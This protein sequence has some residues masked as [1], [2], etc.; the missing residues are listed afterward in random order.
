MKIENIELSELIKIIEVSRSKS[1]V[2]RKLGICDGTHKNGTQAKKLNAIIE[3]N[4]LDT[5]HFVTNFTNTEIYNKIPIVIH[6]CNSIK[7]VGIKIGIAKEHKNMRSGYYTRIKKYIK[8]NNINIDHFNCLGRYRN[9]HRRFDNDAVFTM[10]TET[11]N[12][13]VK[14][15]F[16]KLRIESYHCDIC[17]LEKWRETEINL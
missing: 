13:T 16:I 11:S 8:E 7:E 12:I 3:E 2:L 15:R 6:D 17:L 1:D 9:S 10:N 4:N 14:N 5:K